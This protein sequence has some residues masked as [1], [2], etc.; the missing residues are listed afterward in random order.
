MGRY[1]DARKILP[2]LHVS[3]TLA[4]VCLKNRV[5][6][7]QVISANIKRPSLQM[8]LKLNLIMKKLMLIVLSLNMKLQLTTRSR[9]H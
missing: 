8:R 3:S 4:P 9:Q 5:N 7:F 6:V 2:H 1:S